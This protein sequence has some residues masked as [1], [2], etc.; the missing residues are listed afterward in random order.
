[1]IRGGRSERFAHSAV[2]Q[3]FFTY[4]GQAGVDNDSKITGL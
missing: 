1:M 3:D 2:R 4:G